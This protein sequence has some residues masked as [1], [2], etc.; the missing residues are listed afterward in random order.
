MGGNY[1]KNINKSKL[2]FLQDFREPFFYHGQNNIYVPNLPENG[3][4]KNRSNAHLCWASRI[5]PSR[6]SS[7]RCGRVLWTTRWRWSCTAD[8]PR[9]KSFCS[10]R[11]T[12]SPAP[13]APAA[14][15]PGEDDSPPESW[16]RPGRADGKQTWEWKLLFGW[17]QFCM[18]DFLTNMYWFLSGMKG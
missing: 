18:R 17:S 2:N 13:L 3:R 16:V 1:F 4:K 7:T 8:W 11:R 12:P 14:W 9:R 10:F 15:K 6:A 5:S